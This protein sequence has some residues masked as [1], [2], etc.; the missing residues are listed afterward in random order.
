MPYICT[1]TVGIRPCTGT[2]GGNDQLRT[3]L[4]ILKH[5]DVAGWLHGSGKELGGL[6]QS[7]MKLLI[8][9]EYVMA[10]ALHGRVTTIL[11]VK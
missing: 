8:F 5:D 11:T 3:K 7:R 4:L 9:K 2:K 10:L 1:S 6:D